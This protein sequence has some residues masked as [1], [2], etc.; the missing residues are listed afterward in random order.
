MENRDMNGAGVQPI[1][2][3]FMPMGGMGNDDALLN[4]IMRISE[5]ERG[6]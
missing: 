3:M 4:M 2:F 5:L 1:P 6:R